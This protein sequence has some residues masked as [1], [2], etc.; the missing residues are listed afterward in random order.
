MPSLNLHILPE[1]PGMDKAK[2]P[3]K[4]GFLINN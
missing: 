1:F 2:N 4:A 3:A